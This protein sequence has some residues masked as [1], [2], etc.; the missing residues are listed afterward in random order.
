MEKPAYKYRL[1]DLLDL[2][3]RTIILESE[4]GIKKAT[5]YMHR[6][7]PLG[8]SRTITEFDLAKYAAFFGVAE[9]EIRNYAPVEKKKAR[10]VFEI[11][12]TN[13]RPTLDSIASLAGMA[14][15]R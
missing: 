8:A 9:N 7:I 3:P 5:F 2:V 10:T 13:P 15:P 1:N 14:A 4:Y 6:D 12:R 11:L